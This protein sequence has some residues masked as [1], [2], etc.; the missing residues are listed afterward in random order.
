V[1]A[2]ETFTL[3]VEEEYHLVDQHSLGL[4]HAPQVVDAATRR[5][6]AHAQSE[7]STSQVEAST[8]I[9]SNLAEVRAALRH[10]R[11]AAD[12]AAQ[13]HQ[14]RIL[15]AGTHPFGTWKD[16]QLTPRVRYLELLERW[17]V[18]ALQQVISGC[19]VHVAVRD[20]AQAV[21]VMNRVR[22]YLPVLLALSGSSPF[23]EGTD[24]GYASYRTQWFSR[25]PVT[26]APDGV[27]SVSAY[28][29]LV[30]QLVECGVIDDASHLYWDVRPS[31][32]FPTLEFRMADVCPFI[33]DA[34]LQAGLA[35]SLT[36]SAAA[37]ADRGDCG[38]QFPGEL[39]R[40]ARWRAARYGLEDQLLDPRELCLRP[41]HAVVRDVLQHLRTDL[42][43]HDEWDEVT[44]LADQALARGTSA[45]Q[46][47]KVF[48]ETGGDLVKVTESLVARSNSL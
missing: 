34:V 27:G 30:T 36:R 42:E 16:Q 32:R 48:M 43:D 9:C 26:G 45:A 46:Q 39:Y 23:W 31:S 40:A 25:W 33:D 3:G 35:R 14:C 24:T 17:G 15:A 1:H 37:A 44:K 6:G 20:L 12:E 19:H 47:R 28:D 4:R 41:A 2:T 38:T 5:L 7:I 11:R 22:P 8:P 21:N 10:A 18:L 29:E 13:D